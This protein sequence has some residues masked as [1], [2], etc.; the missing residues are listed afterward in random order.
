MSG[1]AKLSPSGAYRWMECPGSV[2]A[3]EGLPDANSAAGREGTL[4]HAIAATCL[5]AGVD[6]VAGQ[7]YNVDLDGARAVQVAEPEWAA[8]VQ[9]YLDYVRTLRL[10][11]GGE[12]QIEEPVALAEGGHLPIYGTADALLVSGEFLHVIDLKFGVGKFV[13]AVGNPQLRIY[14]LAALDSLPPEQRDAVRE[15]TIHISQPRCPDAEG[16]TERAVT[17]TVAELRAWEQQELRPAAHAASQPNA[18]L[19]AGDWCGWCPARSSCPALRSR[20]LAVAQAVFPPI[21]GDQS[22]VPHPTVPPPADAL[23][24]ADLARVLAGAEVFGSWLK[25]I[26]E[27]AT[28]RAEQG[29]EIPGYRLEDKWG[30]RQ[31][32]DSNTAAGTFQALG[33]DPFSEPELRSPAQIEKLLGKGGK[34]IV[35]GMVVRPMRGRELVPADAKPRP[36]RAAVFSPLDK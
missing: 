16:D 9:T 17:Y 29:I 30:N 28:K 34:E 11:Y 23:P 5:E 22:L 6:V 31:W 35:A 21:P 18:P 26:R 10:V 14:G 24:V 4:A 12:I 1:H 3:C 33:V 15:V 8:P 2:A 19:A 32:R 7:R 27:E 25:S 20:A 13:A 36:Q